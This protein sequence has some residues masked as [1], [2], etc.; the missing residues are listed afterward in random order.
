MDSVSGESRQELLLNAI[1]KYSDRLLMYT[2][3]GFLAGLVFGMIVGWFLM[4][5]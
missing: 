1:Q 3:F 2:M 5:S 4:K